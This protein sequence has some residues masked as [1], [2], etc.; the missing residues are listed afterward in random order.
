MKV[1]GAAD[2]ERAG[3]EHVAGRLREPTEGESLARLQEEE[4]H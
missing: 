1:V 2:E 3:V 4:E